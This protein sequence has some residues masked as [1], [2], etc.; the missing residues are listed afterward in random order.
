MAFDG[1][2]TTDYDNVVSLNQAYL[3]L[4]RNDDGLSRG[5]G[6]LAQPMRR[7]ITTLDRCEAH[8]LAKTPFLLF[9][10][11][12]SDDL[13][14]NRILAEPIATDLFRSC[15][16]EDVNTVI[17][18]GLGYIW[19][20]AQHNPYA[21]RLTCGATLYWCERIAELTFFR[22]LDAVRSSGDVPLLRCGHQHDLWRKL[23]GSGVS[24]DETIRQAAQVSALQA[25]LTDPPGNR[26]D[27]WSLAARKLRAP[28]LRVAEEN[29]PQD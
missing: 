1:P 28:G 24:R 23:L 2:E 11:R 18:A 6:E 7:R 9:S 26:K 27:T 17:S 5:L 22:L 29:D 8:R 3:R 19:Q 15:P 10:F 20:L 16:S 12:E 25:V 4:I 14:W 13:Y 21:L